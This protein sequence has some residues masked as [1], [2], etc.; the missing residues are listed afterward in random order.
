M[1]KLTLPPPPVE[2]APFNLQKELIEM[3]QMT[4]EELLTI[5]NS[6]VSETQEKLHLQLLEKNQDNKLTETE[7]TLLENLRINA[8]QLMIKKAYAYALLKENY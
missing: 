7:R 3:Q 8:D 4:I 6:K 5:A 1:T 2:Y